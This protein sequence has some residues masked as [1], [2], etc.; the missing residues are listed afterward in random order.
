MVDSR[1]HH[2]HSQHQ[3]E[4]HDYNPT[5]PSHFILKSGDHS[6]VHD[7]VL[8]AE[9]SNSLINP[10]TPRPNSVPIRSSGWSHSSKKIIMHSPEP[11]LPQQFVTSHWLPGDKDSSVSR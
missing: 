3:V 5:S 8:L 7:E 2:S 1:V 11:E 4:K 6:E 10:L 9:E